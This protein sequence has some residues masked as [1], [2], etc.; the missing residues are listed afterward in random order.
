M[1]ENYGVVSEVQTDSAKIAN[2]NITIVG[3][4]NDKKFQRI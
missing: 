4:L 1:N 2:Y 3:I